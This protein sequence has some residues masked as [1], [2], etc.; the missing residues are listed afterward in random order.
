LFVPGNGCFVWLPVNNDGFNEYPNSFSLTT[1]LYWCSYK[2]TD[3][4]HPTVKYCNSFVPAVKPFWPVNI[5]LPK[6]A[7]NPCLPL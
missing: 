5:S 7:N 2:V 3:D 4:D 6:L 1:H